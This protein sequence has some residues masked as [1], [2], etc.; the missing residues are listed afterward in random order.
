[1]ESLGW[2]LWLFQ[3]VSRNLLGQ[4][5]ATAELGK[6]RF[7]HL[8]LPQHPPSLLWPFLEKSKSSIIRS[9]L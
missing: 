2:S 9:D 4:Q 7:Q 5:K 8:C 6:G 1:M 3:T